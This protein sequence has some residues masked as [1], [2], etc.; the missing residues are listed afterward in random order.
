M[1]LDTKLESDSSQEQTYVFLVPPSTSIKQH[2]RSVSYGDSS[3]LGTNNVT[4]RPSALKSSNSKGHKRAFSHGQISGGGIPHKT[5]HHRVGSKTDFIL[6]PGHKDTPEY[7]TGS[8]VFNKGHSRQ[9]S[10][11][12]SIYTLRRADV[13]AAWK[14]LFSWLW[15]CRKIDDKGESKIRTIVPN[16]LVPLKTPLNEHPNGKS[17]S[18]KVRTTKYTFLSFLPKNLLEQFHRVANLYFIFIVLLNWFPA[19]NAFGKEVAMIPVV[20]VL[21][22]TAVKD[23]FEDRRRR[24]SDNRINNSTCRIYKRYLFV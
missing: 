17:P 15:C 20:F 14:K 8:S 1:S 16:H 7:Y 23:L 19:I 4:S 24:I 10:R 21:S 3:Y 12:E 6:P 9:A 13:P 18:N 2:N 11:S 22:V 5:G